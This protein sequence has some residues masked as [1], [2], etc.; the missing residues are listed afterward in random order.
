MSC[1]RSN[2]VNGIYHKG[3]KMK[4]QILKSYVEDF[5]DN[6]ELGLLKEAEIFEKFV[7]YCVVSRQYPREFDFEILSVGGSD[8]IGIDG[9]AFIVNGNIIRNPEEIDYLRTKNG[10]LEASF[11]FIQSK[12]SVH[13]KGDQVGTLI[14]GIK[15]FFD[16]IPAIPENDEIKNL[17]TIKNEIYK[18]TISLEEP[19]TLDIFFVTTGEWKEPAQITG[20]VSRELIELK[21]KQL[22][23]NII[24]HFYDAE[25][26]KQSYREI[27]RKIIKEINFI[28]RVALPDIG[29]VRQAFVG[30]IS[31]IEFVKLITDSDCKLQ[32]N[33]FEDNVRDFQGNN[34]VNKEIDSTL[35]NIESQTALSI[36]NNGITIVAKKVE[37]IGNKIKLTDFQIVNGCQTSHVL[38]ENKNILIDTTHIVIKIIETTDYDLST[39]I[40]RAANRQTEVTDEAFESLSTFHKNLE[41]FYKAQ[42]KKISSPIY[43]ERRSKQY[44]GVSNLKPTS[45]ISLSAQIKSYVSTHLAQPQSTHRYYGELLESNRSRMFNENDKLE[46][47]YIAALLLN[48][49][50]ASFRR[51]SINPKYKIFKNHIIYMAYQYF[52]V[53]MSSDK[54]ITYEDI[55]NN[56]ADNNKS[57]LLFKTAITSISKHIK[58]QNLSDFDAVRSKDFTE[59]LKEEMNKLSNVRSR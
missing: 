55:I 56:I 27:N 38:F 4:D 3:G 2:I 46:L 45:I 34:K 28:N 20:R 29:G 51:G 59:R 1:G 50:D 42:T 33:L 26:L 18:N 48:K 35:K 23:S 17:R 16:D 9:A 44:D 41:E 31:T 57:D 39:K 13:F 52:I 22:F 14:F 47:Y 24:F 19:P 15:S 54:K 58:T 7:N 10:Y 21:D 12:S 11:S 53:L 6:N 37:P 43:Y 49:V 40:I 25:K 8:D 5:R 32:K 36:F 30:S